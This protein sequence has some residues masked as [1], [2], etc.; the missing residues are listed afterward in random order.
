MEE[1]DICPN[2]GLHPLGYGEVENCG[3]HINPP[4]SRCVEN[5]L[6][7]TTCGYEEETD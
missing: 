3:C 2:C 7:C 4:C 5:P 6:V 1:G